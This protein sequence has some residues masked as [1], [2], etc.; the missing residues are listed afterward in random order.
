[1]GQR[2]DGSGD[3]LYNVY[4]CCKKSLGTHLRNICI[5][6]KNCIL[7]DIYLHHQDD[8]M[9]ALHHVLHHILVTS[10]CFIGLVIPA[11]AGPT[12]QESGGRM[13]LSGINSHGQPPHHSKQACNK[14]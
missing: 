5:K 8:V 7:K 2:N 6:L 11:L 10:Q 3:A 9:L 12:G 4:P 14:S 1:V 13:T